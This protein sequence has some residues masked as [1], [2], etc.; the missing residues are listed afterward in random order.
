MVIAADNTAI[1]ND[2]LDRQK[3][4]F[5]GLQ[6]TEPEPGGV[7]SEF[8]PEQVWRSYMDFWT[9]FSRAVPTQIGALDGGAIEALVDPT[10]GARNSLGPPEARMPFSQG[11]SFANLWDWNDK[12][13]KVYGAW[14]ELQQ[15][16]AAQRSIV[17]AAW[18]DATRL[19]QE[20]ISH[21]VDEQ[22]PP[23]TTWRAGLDLWLATANQRLLEM[24]RSPEFLEAQ[25]RLLAA[26]MEYRV[27]LRQI[28]EELCETY[29]IPGRSEVDE[30]ARTVHELRRDMRAL[31]RKDKSTPFSGGAI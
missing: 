20:L 1:M 24:Q 27:K 17:D 12:T 21:P 6:P 26:S 2:W 16:I 25:R 29:Q 13:Q 11:P 31:K 18:S 30:L 15:E 10:A 4:F 9:S 7:H 8:K 3:E 28:A 19:Y 22:H 5:K 14:L 23:I